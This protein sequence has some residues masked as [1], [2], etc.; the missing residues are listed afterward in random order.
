MFALHSGVHG[1]TGL[2]LFYIPIHMHLYICEFTRVLASHAGFHGGTGVHLSRLRRQRQIEADAHLHARL[3]R[4]P[5]RR[6]PGHLPRI[7]AHSQ[8]GQSIDIYIYI[9]M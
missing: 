2:H 5:R 8:Q 4:T 3:R 7:H 6:L 9:C 1:G